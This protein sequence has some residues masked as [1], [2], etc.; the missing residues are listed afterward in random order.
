MPVEACSA[1]DKPG[2]RWGNQGKCYT[3]TPGDKLSMQEAKE[4][5]NKQGVAARLAGYMEKEKV[6]STE[7]MESGVKNP[8]QGYG[9]KEEKEK[10]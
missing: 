3:Y 10:K 1:G 6:I 4:K 7:S 8:Q 5:A 2:F 9:K